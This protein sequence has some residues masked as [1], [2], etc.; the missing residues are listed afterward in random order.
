[1]ERFVHLPL[2]EVI[3]YNNKNSKVSLSRDVIYYC[4]S[5]EGVVVS[6]PSIA[7]VTCKTCIENFSNAVTLHAVGLVKDPKETDG[8]VHTM[9][10]D[11]FILKAHVESKDCWCEPELIGDYSAVGGVKHYLHR[12]A[13]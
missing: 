2:Q 9:P 12:E 7:L 13:H 3:F 5:F 10:I 1:M 11:S 8:N 6:S 4:G